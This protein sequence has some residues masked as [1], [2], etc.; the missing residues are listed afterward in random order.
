LVGKRSRQGARTSLTPNQRNNQFISR[1]LDRTGKLPHLIE[2]IAGRCEISTIPQRA[3]IKCIP[4]L[5]LIISYCH[6]WVLPRNL[7]LVM[8][9]VCSNEGKAE[10]GL[11]SRKV[12]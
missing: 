2:R 7:A 6:I 10:S 12:A 3:S 9:R 4:L 8:C 5:F 1:A 11:E